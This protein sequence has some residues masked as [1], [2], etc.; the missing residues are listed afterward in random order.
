MKVS[1]GGGDWQAR[2]GWDHSLAAPCSNYNILC[3]VCVNVCV[4][5]CHWLHMYKWAFAGDFGQHMRP[6]NY[7]SLFFLPSLKWLFFIA[8]SSWYFLHVGTKDTLFCFGSFL[9]HFGFLL[10]FSL[11]Y[12]FWR[13]FPDCKSPYL[14]FLL[15]LRSD[16]DFYSNSGSHYYVSCEWSNL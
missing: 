14:N 6:L 15:K 8:T 12:W 16:P 2:R 10:K 3:L 4:C 9:L 13:Y 7:A 5:V 1:E 11:V